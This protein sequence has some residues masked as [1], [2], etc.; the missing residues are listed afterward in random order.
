MISKSIYVHILICRFTDGGGDGGGD[1]CVGDVALGR[2]EGLGLGDG[3]GGCC[4]TQW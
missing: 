1:E 4:R 2:V 3:G